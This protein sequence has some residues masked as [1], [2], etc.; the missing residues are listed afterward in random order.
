MAIDPSRTPIYH[1]TQIENLERIIAQGRLLSD[2]AMIAGG[3]QTTPIGDSDIKRRRLHDISTDCPPHR[4]VGEF[5]PFYYCP[6]SPMLYRINM[7]GTGLA[8]GCQADIVHLVSTVDAAIQ[9]GQDWVIADGNAGAFHTSFTNE[10]D[11]LDDLNWSAINAKYWSGALMHHKQA[12]FLVADSYDWQA[13][14]R[15]ACYNP[16]AKAKVERVLENAYYSPNVIA[17]PGWYY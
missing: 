16:E 15:I 3:H 4:M 13:I 9:L 2:A 14:Q 8:A 6:R 10:I 7:G 17:M 12:E 1:I 5:V 11:G